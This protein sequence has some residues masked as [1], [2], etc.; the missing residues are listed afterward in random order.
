M[1]SS[2]RVGLGKNNLWDS[3]KTHLQIRAH[4]QK[5]YNKLKKC[6]NTEYRI[7]F[8]SKN[9]NNVNDMISQIKSVNKDYYIVKLF[10]YLEKC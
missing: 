3:F 4:C 8:T 7:D 6:K 2:I 1:I 5:Y 9:I 10:L